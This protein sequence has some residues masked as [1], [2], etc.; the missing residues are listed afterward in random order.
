MYVKLS[1]E[2]LSLD[3]SFVTS[4][5]NIN[6]YE[7]TIMLRVLCLDLMGARDKKMNGVGKVII[8]T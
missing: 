4:P 3:P 7:M 6:T 8:H 5:T 2:D 1:L